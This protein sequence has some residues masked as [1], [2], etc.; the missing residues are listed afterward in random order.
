MFPKRF[1]EYSRHQVV[2]KLHRE[3]KT[4]MTFNNCEERVRNILILSDRR[5]VL[6][7]LLIMFVFN[8]F[9]IEVFCLQSLNMN[10]Y[11]TPVLAE[12]ES[13]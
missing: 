6:F 11:C 5:I 7:E 12:D 2:L 8:I 3:K 10:F 13:F 9:I 1:R 4:Y